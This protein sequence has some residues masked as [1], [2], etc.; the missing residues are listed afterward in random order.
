M[1]HHHNHHHQPSP[2][3]ISGDFGTALMAGGGVVAATEAIK[4]ANSR[5]HTGEHM[6]GVALGT[7]TAVAG[8]EI[9]HKN[10]MFRT[11]L[12]PIVVHWWPLP[13]LY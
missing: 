7:A 10:C 4:A 6:G 1:S 3:T 5:H 13:L 12:R 11:L 8:Y 9:A 2:H